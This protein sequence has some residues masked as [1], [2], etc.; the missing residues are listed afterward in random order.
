MKSLY[1]IRH[2]KSSWEYS[3]LHDL[4]RPLT[5]RGKRDAVIMGTLLRKQNVHPGIVISSPALRA[6]STCRIIC[7]EIGYDKSRIEINTSLYF[8][9]V[10]E[11]LA[12]IHSRGSRHDDMFLF[13][14][15]PNFS[16]LAHTFSPEFDEIIP[17]CGIVCIRFEAESWGLAEAGSGK[18]EYFDMPK[19][20]R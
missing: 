3:E 11:I 20:Y 18:L 13:G 14:H 9:D 8:K 17:T 19:N 7:D 6:I 2:A 15:N 12:V 1:I 4:E 10:E 5:D 16:N